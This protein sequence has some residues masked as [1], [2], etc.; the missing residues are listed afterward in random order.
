MT[1][2]EQIQRMI[3]EAEEACD[4]AIARRSIQLLSFYGG[5]I[6]ALKDVLKLLEIDQSS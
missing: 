5:R 3:K 2:I 6:S 1:L 4:E